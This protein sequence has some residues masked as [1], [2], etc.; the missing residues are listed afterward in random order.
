MHGRP[1]EG[2]PYITGRRL[3]CVHY[4]QY[5]TPDPF[6]AERGFWHHFGFSVGSAC[7]K[8]LRRIAWT[9]PEVRHHSAGPAARD[10]RV[11][12]RCVAGPE[13]QGPSRSRVQ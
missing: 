10:A 8:F 1:S 11:E 13:G 9:N 2:L 6:V 5:P 12:A 4:L 3:E 7:L